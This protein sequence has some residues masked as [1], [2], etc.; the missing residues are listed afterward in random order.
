MAYVLKSDLEGK[1]PASLILQALDDDNDGIEDAGAWDE[2]VV[3]VES[4]IN[5]RLEGNYDIPLA[6]PLPAIISEAA[7]ILAAEAIYMRR[8][9]AG[10][11]NPWIKQADMMRK[12]L[13]DIGSGEK[14]LKPGTNP[15]GPTGAVITE[16][17]RINT[18]GTMMI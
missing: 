1:I 8:G 16:Q 14:P 2:L 6:L 12:R 13:E 9:I 18:P 3:D 11:Q 10:E 5:S 17:S 4:A 7:K 15:A